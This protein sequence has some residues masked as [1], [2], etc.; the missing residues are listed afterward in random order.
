M[1]IMVLLVLRIGF[2]QNIMKLLLDVLD[3]LNKFGCLIIL[4]LIM[5]GLL[6][7]RCNGKIYIN[8]SQWMEPQTHLKRDVANIV[9]E[10]SIVAMLT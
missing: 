7:C 10:G 9:V 4:S 5:G 8:G 1:L 2:L 3:P 6:L